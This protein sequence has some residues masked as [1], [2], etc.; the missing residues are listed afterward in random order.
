MISICCCMIT[1]ISPDKYNYGLI[2]FVKIMLMLYNDSPIMNKKQYKKLSK[3][4]SP[5]T[6]FYNMRHY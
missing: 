4:V 1:N 3:L 2:E 6:Y 5:K